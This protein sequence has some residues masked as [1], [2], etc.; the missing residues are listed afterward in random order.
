MQTEYR[1]VAEHAR[2]AR[3]Q[4][5]GGKGRDVSDASDFVDSYLSGKNSGA[6]LFN[7]ENGNVHKS[8]PSFNM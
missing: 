4:R 1:I 8:N 3:K 6:S 2:A 7:Q 5:N